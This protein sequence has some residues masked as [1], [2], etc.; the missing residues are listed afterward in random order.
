MGTFDPLPNMHNEVLVSLN[1][2]RLRYWLSHRTTVSEPV[3]A[4]L[5]NLLSHVGIL[6][7]LSGSGWLFSEYVTFEKDFSLFFHTRH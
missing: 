7:Y 1:I 2:E 4:L 3:A 6:E 5:G